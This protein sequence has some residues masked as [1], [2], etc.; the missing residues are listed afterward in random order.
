MVWLNLRASQKCLAVSTAETLARFRDS[1]NARAYPCFDLF[2]LHTQP[3]KIIAA[4]QCDPRRVQYCSTGTDIY[5]RNTCTK[6]AAVGPLTAYIYLLSKRSRGPFFGC[7]SLGQVRQRLRVEPFRGRRMHPGERIRGGKPRLVRR[8]GLRLLHVS[9]LPV[10][11]PQLPF[12]DGRFQ[13]HERGRRV[14]QPRGHWPGN[15]W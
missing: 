1:V 3:A 8:R 13:V 12:P 15:N 2:V 11:P 6:H 4:H 7:S 10:L 14:R 9:L 5:L